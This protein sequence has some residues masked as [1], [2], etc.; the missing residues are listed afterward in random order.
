MVLG[1]PKDATKEQI[2]SAYKKLARK[3]HPDAN[4]DSDEVWRYYDIRGAY[5][6]LEETGDSSV[7]SPEETQNRP[8]SPPAC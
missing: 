3:Y 6:Y 7:S 8:L 5:E 2:K 1:L 4:P